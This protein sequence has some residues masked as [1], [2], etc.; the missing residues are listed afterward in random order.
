MSLLF[1]GVLV[2]G[3]YLFVFVAGMALPPGL[4]GGVL[5]W[6]PQTRR[7][8][9][10]VCCAFAF[11]VGG[12]GGLILAVPPDQSDKAFAIEMVR[13]LWLAFL[14][15]AMVPFAAVGTFLLFPRNTR[16]YGK[17]LLGSFLFVPLGAV[18]MWYLSP[19]VMPEWRS[20]PATMVNER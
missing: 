9:I 8:S 3:P 11:V 13:M 18:L 16:A 20:A 4:V 6:F 19:V 12:A 14:L 5:A 2:A 17:Q 1:A 7:A 15:S 10:W